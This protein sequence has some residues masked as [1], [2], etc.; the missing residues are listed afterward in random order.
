MEKLQKYRTEYLV[1]KQ[2][3]LTT[4]TDH[5]AICAYTYEYTHTHY[6]TSETKITWKDS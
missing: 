1:R 4:H 2:F 6:T 3:I 5:V